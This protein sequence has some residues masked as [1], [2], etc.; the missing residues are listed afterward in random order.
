MFADDSVAVTCICLV[1]RY[2]SC[3]GS[4]ILDLSRLHIYSLHK[5]NKGVPSAVGFPHCAGSGEGLYIL[6]IL[7]KKV[8]LDKVW[9]KHWKYKSLITFKVL[10]F[11]IQKSYE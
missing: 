10:S 8:V 11:K 9:V 6:S 2:N 4:S 1:L 7:E 5:K 3:G